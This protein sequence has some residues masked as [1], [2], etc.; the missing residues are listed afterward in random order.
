[1]PSAITLRP[2]QRE[3]LAQALADAVY[4]RDPPVHC[5][6]C[7]VPRLRGHAGPRQRLPR[8]GSRARSGATG[9]TDAERAARALLVWCGFC[10]AP[11]GALCADGGQHLARYLRAH[12]RGL[13]GRD[14]M[15]AV[16]RSLPV[17]SAGQIVAD[18]TVPASAH[19]GAAM[20]PRAEHCGG[21]R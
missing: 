5:R 14:D 16:C 11:P 8:S 15:K 13:I 3:L 4:Y 6:A 12:R 18:T 9:V 19:G 10:W 21:K 7:A 20:T 17:V 2:Q 1:M